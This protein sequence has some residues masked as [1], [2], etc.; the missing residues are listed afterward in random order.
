MRVKPAAF[1]MDLEAAARQQVVGDGI[2]RPHGTARTARNPRRRRSTPTLARPRNWCRHAVSRVIFHRPI[3][4]RLQ[5]AP[6]GSHGRKRQAE[7]A[8]HRRRHWRGRGRMPAAPRAGCRIRGP[9]WRRAAGRFAG[10]RAPCDVAAAQRCRRRRRR[11]ANMP[12]RDARAVSTGTI[13]SAVIRTGVGILVRHS[14]R[15]P[16]I[17]RGCGAGLR[18]PGL[19]HASGGL[20]ASQR[21]ARDDREVMHLQRR[22]QESPE[23]SK[24]TRR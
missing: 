17:P 15:L 11:T 10:R 7:R 16:G 12:R 22:R 13:W 6:V 19:R 14:A 24:N 2:V 8:D 21:S 23:I 4:V 20:R 3:L 5:L 9:S 18:S 1:R